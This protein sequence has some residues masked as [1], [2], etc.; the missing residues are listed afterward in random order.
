MYCSTLHNL[1]FYIILCTAAH[2]TYKILHDASTAVNF[3]FNILHYNYYIVLISCALSKWIMYYNTLKMIFW[4][5]VN[6][7][8]L[9]NM[10]GSWKLYV[11]LSQDFADCISV[12]FWSSIVP[13]RLSRED[14]TFITLKLCGLQPVKNTRTLTRRVH[15]DQ[16]SLRMNLI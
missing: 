10:S 11:P 9:D 2:C 8:R 3:N 13:S 14:E 1:M 16:S 7:F 15:L 4:L 5:N 6:Y 12:A